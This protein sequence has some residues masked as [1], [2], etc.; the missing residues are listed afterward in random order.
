MFR[1]WK[2]TRGKDKRDMVQEK[3]RRMEEE[4]RKAKAVEL[5]QQGAWTRWN[6]LKR[7]V[8]W[9]EL[10]RM[11]PL[12]ISFLLRSVSDVLPSPSNLLK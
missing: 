2:S 6:V 9:S 11:E 3:V 1:Q 7:K 8:T 12:R 10:W 5:G 4:L